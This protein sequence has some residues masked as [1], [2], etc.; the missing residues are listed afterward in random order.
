[1]NK[2]SSWL[3]NFIQYLWT[4]VA[5]ALVVG[6]VVMSLVRLALPL[7]PQ[8]R[9]DITQ[10]IQ[11]QYGVD[12]GIG[13]VDA[14][15]QTYGPKLIFK[16]L[17]F[18]M[19]E[20]TVL[21]IDVKEIEAQL[22]FWR[23]LLH[24]RPIVG[25]VTLSG[26]AIT[27]NLD[28]Q[29]VQ[30]SN[31]KIEIEQV[32]Q[33][34]LTQLNSFTIT[35]SQVLLTENNNQWL[36]NIPEMEWGNWRQGHRGFGRLQ[37]Q[38][39]SDNTIDF[40]INIDE[41][42]DKL[43]GTFY[44]E[45][46]DM[47]LSEVITR[48]FPT[49]TSD[50]ETQLN[51]QLWADFTDNDVDAVQ[52]SFNQSE[53]NWYN[54]EQF[55]VSILN[56]VLSANKQQ[57]QWQ[58]VLNDLALSVEQQP[59]L[60]NLQGQIGRQGSHMA[61]IEALDLS[62]LFPFVANVSDNARFTALVASGLIT[63]LSNIH[64][65]YD[66]A[67]YG[68]SVDIDSISLDASDSSPAIPNLQ[69][70][71][72][73]W[74]KNGYISV[75]AGPGLWDS[76]GILA[77]ERPFE[78][79]SVDTY[80]E[81]EFD[82]LSIYPTVSLTSS[83]LDLNAKAKYN[84]ASQH[85]SLTADIDD[86]SLTT[87]K[88]LL[89][90]RF[91]PANTKRFLNRS[92]RAGMVNNAHILW[93]GKLSQY[94]FDD[95]SGI[96]QAGINL[97]L[98]DF[99]FNPK[100]PSLKDL[101]LNL[102]F[103]NNDL[104][105]SAEKAQI[106]DAKLYNLVAKLP[107]LKKAKYL[108][109]DTESDASGVVLQQLLAQ[110]PLQKRVAEPLTHVIIDDPLDLKLSLKI[111][112]KPGLVIAKGTALLDNN[113]L[114]FPDINVSLQ[115]VSGELSFVNEVINAPDLTAKLF[116]FPISMAVNAEQNDKSIYTT[117]AE[118]S[119]QW[120]LG[121]VFKQH[122]IPLRDKVSGD[123]SWKGDLELL[124][125]KDDFDYSFQVSSDLLGVASELPF[126][127]GKKA[128]DPSLLFIDAEGDITASSIRAIANQHI[129][130]NGR[131]PHAN[132]QFSRAKLNVGETEL[133]GLGNGFSI[134]VAL[135]SIDLIR[136]TDDLMAIFAGK[137]Q[138][139]N[140]F[141][142][143]LGEPQYVFVNTP[144]LIIGDYQLTD[145]EAKV[146]P[147]DSHWASAMNSKEF[148]ADINF[149]R[150]WLEKGVAI[151][152]DYLNIQQQAPSSLV[153]ADSKPDRDF[154]SVPPVQLQCADCRVNNIDFGRVSL[155]SR[156]SEDQ[157]II[158]SFSSSQRYMDATITGRWGLSPQQ[159][160]AQLDGTLNSRDMGV[161]LTQFDVSTGLR[162][163]GGVIDFSLGWDDALVNIDL[164]SLDGSLD[165]NLDDG[166]LKEFND[167]GSQVSRVLGLLSLKSLLRKLRF[168]FRDVFNQGFFFEDLSG[169]FALQDGIAITDDFFIDGPGLDF[170]M[171]GALNLNNE[172][173][174]FNVGVIPNLTSS[175][176]VLLWMLNPGVGLAGLAIDE[177]IKSAKVVS[178]I[179]YQIS[180]TLKQPN[181]SEL[182]R[183]TKALDLES[184]L[185]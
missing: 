87:V 53:L 1:M 174:D 98:D 49:L 106:A 45:T 12:V 28:A 167:E 181:V 160:F 10:Y 147:T 11:Q 54:P 42:S 76:A 61:Y 16:Q 37:L 48:I 141:T 7:L 93:H 50:I 17:Q 31:A 65:Y 152:A 150:Q 23:S 114:Y 36:I 99:A 19:T 58:Y 126:P 163:A 145:F 82:G 134:S 9:S 108:Y 59:Q 162:D 15:W 100:W 85:L 55:N 103:E 177:A 155:V 184:P 169:S 63:E 156:R 136:W 146:K 153:T 158:D 140:S 115:Q 138:S 29:D 154:R 34:F 176:P 142:S 101:D 92:L 20:Q 67:N 78:A 84:T 161:W 4:G 102:V 122:N 170:S 27:S 44:A 80:I 30:S 46:Q 124:F 25:N 38:G 133:M 109:V 185:N 110:S 131:L 149:S 70:Q 75:N 117:K 118:F 71:A 127:F 129:K 33:F 26:L 13:R 66:V 180:G 183:D 151:N 40:V 62:P 68:L 144:K 47:N 32:Q 96:F 52:A 72:S 165:F 139:T 90:T 3:S 8:Y 178:N 125:P 172:Q 120:P 135:P 104:E 148:R 73:W 43:N 81:P 173:I 35:D 112:L 5:I 130:F 175:F 64:L 168:D 128:T 159:P 97:R 123:L 182:S 166:Y 164:A 121:S 95:N 39:I 83:D 41:F 2:A 86:L 6:A 69:G 113:T 60:V 24:W 57:G 18:E 105:F 179:Q 137:G 22:S 77:K 74:N 88:T 89:E 14:V 171:K 107:N 119:G 51:M 132:K 79:F 56:G 21:T 116:N 157:F 94:P 91:I 143:V 111:P